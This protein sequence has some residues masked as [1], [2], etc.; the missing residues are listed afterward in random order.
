[1]TVINDEEEEILYEDECETIYK[2][3]KMPQAVSN[4]KIHFYYDENMQ[5][6][7]ENEKEDDRRSYFNL[8]NLK[9]FSSLK[10]TNN[11][12]N[13]LGNLSNLP[14]FDRLQEINNI[15]NNI[16]NLSRGNI[17]SN[18][19]ATNFNQFIPTN[20][21]H[22]Q[23]MS[24]KSILDMDDD[25]FAFYK[26]KQYPKKNKITNLL[27]TEEN[28]ST[29]DHQEMIGL[30]AIKQAIRGPLSNITNNFDQ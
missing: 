27:L 17:S 14:K 2:K 3:R 30:K 25:N 19:T 23:M 11:K 29:R 4:H 22:A 13:N 7:N 12:M 10:N 16:S 28:S 24:N 18:I 21:K 26:L 8:S 1:M 20:S 6:N 5:Q 15:G 9:N